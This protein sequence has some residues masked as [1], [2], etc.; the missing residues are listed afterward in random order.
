M[1]WSLLGGLLGLGLGVVVATLWTRRWALRQMQRVRSAERRARSAERLAEL[2]SMTG[3]LAHEIKNPLSTIGLNAQ[4]LAEGIA[5]LRPQSDDTARLSR[6]VGSLTREVERLSGILSDFLD[7]AGDKKLS[8]AETDLNTLVSELTDFVHPQAER[9]KVRL[10]TT[11]PTP[12]LRASVDAAL[13]KQALL[14]L[15]LNALQA[16]EGSADDEMPREL[17]V[18]VEAG[19]DDGEPTVVLRVADTGPGMDEATKQKLFTPYF[20][21]KPGG[22]GLG[23]PTTRRI[24]EQHRGRI[25]VFSARDHGTEFV[26]T[27]PRSSPDREA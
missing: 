10:R 16:M 25:E 13:L 4:L 26:I 17:L 6:R 3:G 22:T 24:V 21:T 12:A 7:F 14:N 1:V 15:M 18:R 27:L 23:L 5:E 11:L 8:P 19:D 2:G 9:L 20:T